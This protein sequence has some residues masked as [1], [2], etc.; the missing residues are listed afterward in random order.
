MPSTSERNYK[1]KLRNNL[2]KKNPY[3]EYCFNL[4]MKFSPHT[5]TDLKRNEPSP[6]CTRNNI[7]NVYKLKIH[8]DFTTLIIQT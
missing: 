2:K 5:V 8:I 3:I 6:S 1:G 4:H 7:N